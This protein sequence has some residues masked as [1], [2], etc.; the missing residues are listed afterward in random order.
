[1]K[2][3]HIHRH[4]RHGAR[5]L[6]LDGLGRLDEQVVEHGAHVHRAEQQQRDAAGDERAF[7]GSLCFGRVHTC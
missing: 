1:M 6:D 3:P 5:G 7:A 4:R 2:P